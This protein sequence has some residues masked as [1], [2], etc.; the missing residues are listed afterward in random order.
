MVVVNASILRIIRIP[1]TFLVVVN[2]SVASGCVNKFLA[3]GNVPSYFLEQFRDLLQS[4]SWTTSTKPRLENCATCSECSRSTCAS[5]N[6]VLAKAQAESSALTPYQRNPSANCCVPSI[7]QSRRD[8]D[9]AEQS[10]AMEA[11]FEAL[12]QELKRKSPQPQPDDKR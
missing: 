10:P 11:Q 9:K 12:K 5:W 4:G 6:V 8:H 7:S 1:I 3:V 2:I